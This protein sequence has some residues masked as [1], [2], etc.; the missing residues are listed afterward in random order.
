MALSLKQIYEFRDEIKLFDKSTSG[1][2]YTATA[3]RMR[4]ETLYLDNEFFLPGAVFY[5]QKKV[6]HVQ[7]EPFPRNSLKG[8]IS[9]GKKPFLLLTEGWRL[10]LDNI[11]KN[12]YELIAEHQ[13]YVLIK[14]LK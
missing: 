5:S 3:A 14:V 2:A 9:F 7:G 13:D 8:I 12:R 6:Y 11:E 10:N 1:L 4:P